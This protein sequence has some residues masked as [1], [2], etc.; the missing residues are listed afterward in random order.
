M[1][2]PL[3]LMRYLPLAARFIRDGRLPELLNQV[4]GK[5]TPAGARFKGLREDLGLFKDLCWA[6]IRGE[7]RDV[8]HR[9]LL[10]VVAAL[11]YFVSPLDA[12]PDWLVAFGFVDDLAVLAWVMQRWRGEMEAFR[13]WRER[14]NSP[15]VNELVRALPAPE[16]TTPPI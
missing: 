15:V 11:V 9:T 8:S 7:Y 2:T 10:M 4:A 6:W 1:K 16:Q 3:K 13:A 14:R 5:S 12:I